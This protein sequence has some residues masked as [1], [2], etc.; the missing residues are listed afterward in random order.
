LS[1]FEGIYPK[2]H[3]INNSRAKRNSDLAR[4]FMLGEKWREKPPDRMVAGEVMELVDWLDVEN[5]IRYKKLASGQTF[6]NIYAYDY[7]C[8]AGVYLPH[9]WWTDQVIKDMDE[10]KT[11][12][13]RYPDTIAELNANA[14]FDWLVKYSYLYGWYKC[15]EESVVQELV[16]EGNVGV[17]CAKGRIGHIT[18]VLPE[19]YTTYQ[20]D[21]GYLRKINGEKDKTGKKMLLQS[22][23]GWENKGVFSD[24]WYEE[25]KQ[26]GF[27][28]NLKGRE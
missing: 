22:Q 16:N 20:E 23:A 1:K 14:T 7:C 21:T 17:V 2:V 13:K 27:W 10:G 25:F 9:V 19:G 11:V 12:E 5:S 3:L 26:F 28:V 24:R 8:Q 18:I 15:G 4:G 6:C